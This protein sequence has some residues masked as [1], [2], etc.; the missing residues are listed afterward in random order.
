[1]LVH[2][3]LALGFV[4]SCVVSYAAAVPFVSDDNLF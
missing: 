4:V 3:V 2:A 1:M